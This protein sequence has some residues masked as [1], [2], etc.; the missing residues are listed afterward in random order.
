MNVDWPPFY[1]TRDFR[2]YENE[3]ERKKV[4]SISFLFFVL[5]Y[6]DFHK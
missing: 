6:F 5:F 1:N 2:A 4:F 3:E